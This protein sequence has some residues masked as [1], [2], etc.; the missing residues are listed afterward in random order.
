MYVVYV[1][2][3]RGSDVCVYGEYMVCV[4]DVCVVYVVCGVCVVCV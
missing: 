1:M 2:Y 3:V 4:C